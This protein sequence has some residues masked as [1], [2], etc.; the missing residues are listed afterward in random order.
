MGTAHLVEDVDMSVTITS[1]LLVLAAAGALVGC[2]K[3]STP[4]PVKAAET[5]ALASPAPSSIATADTTTVDFPLTLPSQLYVEHDAAVLARS[6]GMVQAIMADMGATVAAGQELARLE[7]VDQ[8]I[9]LA[10]AKEKL[11]RTK[12][13]LD[14]QRALTTAGVVTQA[15]SEQVEFEYREAELA[16][17]KAQRDFDLTRIVAPF[18]GVVTSRAARVQRMVNP[19]DSLFRVTAL[20]PILAS[21]R[22][23]ETAASG[24]KVGAEAQVL[25]SGGASAHA[26]V[27]RASP[28]LDAASGTRELVLEVRPGSHLSPGSAV[29]VQL[30]AEH[31][32]VVTIPKA[33]ISREGYALVFEDNRTSLRAVTLGREVGPDRVEVVSGIAPGEKVVRTAP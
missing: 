26:R 33:A 12:Q 9:A 4:A 29:T 2:G 25:G 30:G 13:T 7:S 6:S 1:R 32:Q 27:I 11:A 22:V 10:Q 14:R 18:A 16:L 23:P 21:V 15:D 8:E 20:A 5:G 28:V 24:L 31:R 3:D 19:G 17:R